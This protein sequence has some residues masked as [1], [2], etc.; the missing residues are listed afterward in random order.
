MQNSKGNVKFLSTI[1]SLVW[2]AEISQD[3]NKSISRI[4]ACSYDLFPC[5]SSVEVCG[6]VVHPLKKSNRK[7][8][9]CVVATVNLP[10][11][12]QVVFVFL[13]CEIIP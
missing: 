9:T 13:A 1:T 6:R 5:K 7:Y 2:K 11:S 4:S 3:Q 10:I 12:N 8:R